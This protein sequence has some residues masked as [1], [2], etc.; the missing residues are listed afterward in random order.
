MTISKRNIMIKLCIYIYITFRFHLSISNLFSCKWLSN[1]YIRLTIK[2]TRDALEFW[3]QVTVNKLL[4]DSFHW[5]S[6]KKKT[7]RKKQRPC[8]RIVAKTQPSSISDVDHA[9]WFEEYAALSSI[10]Q[11]Y[12]T[13]L[14]RKT[15]F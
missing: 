9:R 13:E 1:T 8:L 6:I 5:E 12:C 15:V 2:A 14:V 10:R 7:C 3:T 11:P 4:T